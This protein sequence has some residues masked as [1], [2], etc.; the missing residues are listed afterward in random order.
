MLL[1]LALRVVFV[2]QLE[3]NPN[4]QIPILDSDYHVSWARAVAHGEAFAPQVGRPFFRAPLY[5]WFLAGIFAVFGERLLVARLVQCL[6]GAASVGLVYL[7]GR[8]AFDRRV[9]FLAALCAATCWVLVYFDGELLLPVLLVPLDLLALWLM[10]GLATNPRP[11]RSALAGV[12]VGVSAIARPDVLLFAPCVALWLLRRR[13]PGRPR[14]WLAAAAFC[15]A[16]WLPILPITVYNG[17]AGGDF[18]LI[19]SQ[20]G[21]NFWIGNNPT[22]NGVDAVVPGTRGG[23]WEGYQDSIALAEQAEGRP[24]KASEV[25]R[26]YARRAWSFIVGDPDRSLPLLAYKLRL[27]WSAWELGNE[28]EPAFFA[29]RY[30][31]LPRFSLGF[32]SL[33]PLGLLGIWVSRRRADALFPLW[34]FLIIHML[35]VVAFFVCSRFR[36]PVLPVLMVFAA[37][38]L[39]WL[40]ERFRAREW[41]R[42]LPALAFT[43]GAGIWSAAQVP[44]RALIE[45]IGELQLGTAE[46]LRGNHAVAVAHLERAAELVPGNL[47]A[48][49]MLGRA[50]QKLGDAAGA[51]ASYD[52]ALEVAPRSPE[53]LELLLVLLIDEGRLDE[54]E[55]R[56]ERQLRFVAEHGTG[57]RPETPYYQ[58]GRIRA[59]RGDARGAQRAY[60]TALRND[61]HSIRAALALGDL[62]RD[63]KRW[64]AAAGFYRQALRAASPLASGPRQDQASAGLVAALRELGRGDEACREA[65]AWAERRPDLAEARDARREAC[66]PG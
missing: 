57:R 55:Q 23:W 9:G 15:A 33:A 7:V 42:L 61:P 17:V 3:A 62:A 19:S 2:L 37:H 36:V 47:D 50:Q 49:V 41:R 27:F 43:V 8:S 63:E 10:L 25:S 22:S 21:V 16:V 35:G 60:T 65:S 4:H 58:L 39:V 59:A 51:R 6:L 66:A 52:R 29:N 12:W 64:S 48:L 45:S 5:P 28:E 30:S 38:A 24:L 1:A 54:A 34:G 11:A 44:P 46:T 31:A 26:H 32:A 13:V 20:G 14:A 53:A 18:V 56:I 40:H